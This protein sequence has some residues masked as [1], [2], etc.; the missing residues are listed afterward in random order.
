[1]PIDRAASKEMVLNFLNYFD[2][3]NELLNDVQLQ[4]PSI[5]GSEKFNQLKS[6]Y[7]EENFVISGVFGKENI[8][9]ILALPKCEGIRFTLAYGFNKNT[10]II[11]GVQEVQDLTQVYSNDY[12]AK[13]KTYGEG[14]MLGPNGTNPIPPDTEVHKNSKTIAELKAENAISGTGHNQLVDAIFG[15]Y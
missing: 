4:C 2:M 10:I 7:N 5:A 6:Y 1:M 9:Q 15:V 13:S 8:L 11:C 3:A 14:D 12:Q